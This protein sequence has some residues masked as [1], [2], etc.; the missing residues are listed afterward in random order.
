MIERLDPETRQ[1][2]ENGELNL[3]DLKGM[4]IVAGSDYGEEGEFE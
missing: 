3:D 2:F 4:G 1:K